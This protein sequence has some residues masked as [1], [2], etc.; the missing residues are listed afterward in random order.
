MGIATAS[1]E[2]ITWTFD[3]KADYFTLSDGYIHI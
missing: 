1:F 2:E 3:Y